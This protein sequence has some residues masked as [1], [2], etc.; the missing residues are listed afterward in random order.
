MRRKT[1]ENAS[2]K[3]DQLADKIER[4]QCRVTTLVK[5]VFNNCLYY[6]GIRGSLD[7]N[8]HVPGASCRY[9]ISEVCPTKMLV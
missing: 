9:R 6:V 3:L 2:F 8:G 1:L 7:A 4:L 5:H